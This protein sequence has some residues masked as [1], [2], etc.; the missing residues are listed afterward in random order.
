MA[1]LYAQNNGVA[2]STSAS[3]T[4]DASAILDVQ[5][6]SQGVLI[7]KM[8]KAQRDAISTPATS[9]MVYQTDHT[10][11]F[12]YYDGTVWISAIGV[13][14]IN[15]LTDGISDNTKNVFLGTGVGIN[16]VQSGSWAGQ[17]NVALGIKA[18]NQGVNISKSVAIG[19]K[20]LYNN[21]S[22]RNTA[23]G[24]LALETVVNGSGNTAIG[25]EA[26]K[27]TTGNNNTAF[28]EFS[29]A[30][31]G[32]GSNNTAIG[33]QSGDNFT[34]GTENVFLGYGAGY[35]QISGD[36][37][38]AVGASVELANLSASNQMNIGNT[39]Y[40]T[41]MKTAEAKVGIGNNAPNSTLDV[42]GSMALS[43]ASGASIT[44]DETHYVYAA[45]GG[46]TITLPTAVGITGR[47][48]I[49]KSTASTVTIN[50]SSNEN[51]DIAATTSYLLT[52]QGKYV[53]LISTGLAWLVIGQN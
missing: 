48:Y 29:L 33:S 31:L 21:N 4:P 38:I 28:G 53:K 9:L 43:F 22:T 37:N 35:T 12:Y 52:G 46:S 2:I 8:T 36:G 10:P 47:V 32:T 44:L 41:D 15:D 7:P 14:E 18:L 40:A 1:T 50:S 13:K 3:A 24:Y 27:L 39:I 6:T 23:I 11:G 45:D 19:Y 34:T 26:L 51:I 30:K 16:S 5:S 17:Y 42:G 20:T 25:P 49:I